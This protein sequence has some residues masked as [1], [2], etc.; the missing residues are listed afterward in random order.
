MKPYIILAALAALAA[1][2]DGNDWEID[3]AS[4]I[5]RNYA[6][7]TL[8]LDV[9]S[10]R[11]GIKVKYDLPKAGQRY[12][13]QLAETPL[14]EGYDDTP[15]IATFNTADL[16]LE[17]K[18]EIIIPRDNGQIDIRENTDYYVRIRTVSNDGKAPS[19]W[20]TSGIIADKILVQVPPVLTIDQTGIDE[21]QL[22]MKWRKLDKEYAVP[23][24]IRCEGQ[25]DVA[26]D[27]VMA[28]TRQYTA[29]G[30]VAGQEYTFTLLD[31]QG[32]Q[33]GQWTAA[34]EAAPVMEWA[35]HIGDFSAVELGQDAELTSDNPA[36]YGKLIN[37]NKKGDAVKIKPEK[38]KNDWYVNPVKKAFIPADATPDGIDNGIRITTGGKD[39]SITLHVPAKGRLYV[40]THANA[41]RYMLLQQTGDQ[42][43]VKY[44]PAINDAAHKITVPYAD[45]DKT[46]TK[47]ALPA[48]KVYIHQ[49][50]EIT[51]TW[52]ASIYICGFT[53]CP[54]QQL[55]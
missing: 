6:P 3:Q 8:T 7:T 18:G 4:D 48:T 47:A 38:G 37:K 5:N 22:T 23:T 53:F 52:D 21:N 55:Q 25:N 1:C 31:A 20:F 32:Q 26:I 43:P 41:G 35:M 54:D 45:T 39:G 2:T 27:D 15:G 36:F 16:D 29:E 11:N 28:E 50:G 51:I 10:A 34:T 40:Y 30:L 49:A 9:D 14:L 33:I 17:N 12:D 19:K 24:T 46:G 44:A 13:V 42:A